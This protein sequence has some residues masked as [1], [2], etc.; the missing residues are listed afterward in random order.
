MTSV[1]PVLKHLHSPDALNLEDYAPP[2]PQCFSL[3][4]QAMF[5]PNDSDGA[6]SFDILVCNPAWLEKQVNRDVVVSGCHHLVVSRFDLPAIR[7]FLESYG[8][9]CVGKDWQEAATKLAR[10]AHWEFED[11]QPN[12]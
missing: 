9:R 1:W 4:I 11:Y 8:R 3:L 7:S 6:E 10:I 5:G 2:D 12:G